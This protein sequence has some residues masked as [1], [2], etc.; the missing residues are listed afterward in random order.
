MVK[1]PI[2]MIRNPYLRAAVAL[3]GP[4]AIGYARQRYPKYEKYLR[5]VNFKRGGRV[6]KRMC[7]GGMCKKLGVKCKSKRK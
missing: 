4:T 3:G 2:A 1:L 7:M 6:Y 5:S